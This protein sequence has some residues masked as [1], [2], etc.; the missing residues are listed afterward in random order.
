VPP[1]LNPAGGRFLLPPD[2]AVPADG[3]PAQCSTEHENGSAQS[4]EEL[5]DGVASASTSA[6]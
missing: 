5:S 4:G 6:R 1:D 3:V 2:P